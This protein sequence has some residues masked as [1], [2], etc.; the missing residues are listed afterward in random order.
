MET[1]NHTLGIMTEGSDVLCLQKGHLEGEIDTLPSA[2]WKARVFV[3]N[4]SY[5]DP[6]SMSKKQSL[7]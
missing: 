6:G 3:V 5:T 2:I 1:H 4:I 7:T